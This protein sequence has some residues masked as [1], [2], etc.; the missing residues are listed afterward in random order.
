MAFSAKNA[1]LMGLACPITVTVEIGDYSAE[2]IM[3]EAVVNGIKKPCPPQLL[4][5]VQNSLT[6]TKSKVKYGKKPLSD[7]FTA[8]GTF[9]IDGD[10]DL[11][12]YLVVSLGVQSLHVIG[13]KF[14]EKKGV[15]SCK[16]AL[17][18]EGLIVDA[19]FDFVKCTYSI[20]VKNASMVQSGT[21]DFGID[22]FGVSLDGLATVD[23]N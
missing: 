18:I 7:T 8:Q 3:E 15:V 16:G 1:D 4:M 23:I 5:G 21:V 11:S 10:Y 14:I 22:C 19:K 17:S 12:N 6:V 13:N 20:V 9:T 2:V